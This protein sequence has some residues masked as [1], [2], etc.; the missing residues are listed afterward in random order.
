MMKQTL[1]SLLLLAVVA[2][3]S[4]NNAMAFTSQRPVAF[5]QTTTSL[6]LFENL[7]GGGKK[8]EE[9]PK[10]IGGMD[11]DVF[12]GK[13]KRITVREDEDNAMWIEDDSGDRKKT[14]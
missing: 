12:G 13:G 8:K 5:R 4:S 11:A 10:Q 3:L 14:K 6:N 1:S 9:K 7:F 2:L